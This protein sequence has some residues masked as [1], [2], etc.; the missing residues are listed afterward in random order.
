[1]ST[2]EAVCFRLAISALIDKA[3][4]TS[5]TVP[6]SRS[7]TDSIIPSGMSGGRKDVNPTAD[8]ANPE[9]EGSAM[10][11][12]VRLLSLAGLSFDELKPADADAMPVLQCL[13]PD[14]SVC[15]ETMEAVSQD[16]AAVGIRLVLDSA[17]SVSFDRKARSGAYDMVL[18]QRIAAYDDP[19]CLLAEWVSGSPGN[20]CL[21]GDS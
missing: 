2:E 3:F 5:E 4:I 8:P 15:R 14:S 20:Y 12:A 19:L 7:E 6:D 21:F 1:M 13:Y 16:L 17:D 18:D 9:E 10:E 11:K